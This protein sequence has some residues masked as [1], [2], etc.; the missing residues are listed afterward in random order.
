MGALADAAELIGFRSLGVKINFKD[1]EEDAPMPCIVFWNN[2]HFVVVH[3]IKK[4]KIYVAD[5]AFGLVT[6]SKEEFIR[7]WIGQKADENTEEELVLILEPTPELASS[8]TDNYNHR[9]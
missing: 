9:R 1:L 5:P 3:K 7:H 4:G 2:N 8:E 6:F